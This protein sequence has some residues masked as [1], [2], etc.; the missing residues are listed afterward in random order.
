M[1][2]EWKLVFQADQ[3]TKSAQSL[4]GPLKQTAH[5]FM[6]KSGS[7]F[8]IRIKD[9]S[10]H[11]IKAALHHLKEKIC[12]FSPYFIMMDDSAAYQKAAKLIFLG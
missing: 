12:D 4:I 3:G 2:S 11:T 7:L 8:I 1:V 6:Y 5:N 9:E 10:A